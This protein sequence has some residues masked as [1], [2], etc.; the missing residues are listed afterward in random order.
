MSD[1]IHAWLGAIGAHP[2]LVLAIVFATAC[3]EAIALIGTVV[4]AGAV[5]FAAGTLIGAGALDAW[6]AIGVA[7]AGAIVGDGISYELGRRYRGAIRNGWVRLGYADAYARG[8]QFVLRHGIKSIVL[9]RFLAPVR[10]VVPVVVGCATLP[11]RSFYPVNIVSALVW[12]PVHVAPGILFGASAALAAAI[13]VRVAA[14]LLVVAALVAL[15]WIGVRV[16]LRR[17]WPLLRRVLVAAMYACLRRWP[18]LGARLH[19]TL[20]RVRR[21]PG[22]VPVF[23]LLFVGCVWLFAGIVQDVVA[24]DPLMHADVALYAVLQR[25]HTPPVDAA[26]RALAVLHGHDTGLIVAAAFLVWLMIHR[27]WLTSAWWLATV[28]IAV[29]LVPVFG[30]GSPGTM[31]AS[32]PPGALHVPLPDADAAFAMLASSGIGWVLTRDRPALWRIPVVTAVVLWIVLGGFARLYVGETWLSGLLGG[33]SLGLAWFAML[34][35]TYSYWRVREHV[36]PRGALVAV[37]VVL[38]TAGV[39]TVPAQWQLDRAARPHVG[40]VV[41]MSVDQWMRGGW[42]RVPTRRTEI[43]GDREEYL[44][45]QWCATSDTLDRHLALAGWQR[46]TPWSPATALR[47]LLPQ[48]PAD[49]LPVLPR[50]TQGESP[51]RVF[52]RVDPAHPDSRLVLRL[53]RY[54][55]VLQDALG[56]RPL[57]YGALYRETLHRPA[58]L[59]TI[60][61]TT[62]VD[63]AA[64]IA[65]ALRV[66]PTVARP[67]AGMRAAPAAVL[68]VWMVQP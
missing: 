61:R 59:M 58:R 14:I 65:Q 64:T 62:T 53:W 54:P 21:L 15:V 48:A 36:Q 26:M 23:A 5:M 37:L 50:Y 38:A 63:D 20:V 43:G 42:Q 12:A 16:A 49:A 19:D 1:T 29:V 41:A 45:L 27:C 40:D 9:A 10:A 28:G 31:P 46:A 4:P 66:E 47:W 22:A 44:P 51:R 67:P 6:T 24:N 25:L 30:A 60:V 17:G 32:L 57:W 68:L 55:Y 18:R 35:G 11:R 52:V 2:A 56:M 39:W 34:A 8:E 33:W 7:A 3:A 13:S